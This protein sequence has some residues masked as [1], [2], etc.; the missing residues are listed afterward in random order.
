MHSDEIVMASVH[1]LQE[2]WD[3]EWLPEIKGYIDRW[4]AFDLKQASNAELLAHFEQVWEESTRLFAIHFEIVIPVYVSLAL[5]DDLHH[6]LFAED[7]TFDSH[8]LLEGHDN[9]SLQLGRA[10]WNLSRSARAS[11]EVRQIIQERAPGEVV[12]ALAA[13]GDGAQFQRELEGFLSDYGHRGS[14]WGI[15]HTSWIEDPS[16]VITNLKDYMDKVGDPTGQLDEE[17]G[18]APNSGNRHPAAAR[19]ISRRRPGRVRGPVEGGHRRG[20]A[21]RRPR[22]LDRFSSLLRYQTGRG[23]DGTPAASSGCYRRARGCFLPE[24][25]RDQRRSGSLIPPPITP[26]KCASEK[27]SWSI[28]AH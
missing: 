13:S 16:P 10:L 23:R 27:R 1:R 4:E 20:R 21:H 19:G 22:L 11:D 25:S 6:D 7:G 9:T 2:R 12:D 14:L 3:S 15:C 26:T 24:Q 8:R 5:F 17:S 28:L 18:P